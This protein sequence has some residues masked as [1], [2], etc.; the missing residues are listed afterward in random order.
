MFNKTY[1]FIV[2]EGKG[3]SLSQAISRM[4]SRQDTLSKSK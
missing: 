4:E 3:L 1:I 2:I